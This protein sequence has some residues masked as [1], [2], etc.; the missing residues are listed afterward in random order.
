MRTSGAGIVSVI[1]MVVLAA[2]SAA[3]DTRPSISYGGTRQSKAWI[4]VGKVSHA[5]DEGVAWKGVKVYLS[6]TW[7]LIGVDEATGKALWEQS[8]GAFW[9]EIGFAEVE[10]APG[11]K[12]WAVELRPGR[13]G[14]DG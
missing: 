7:N 4:E 6:L 10:T 1:V 9:N 14:E 3:Q 8:V 5:V 12:T 13:A 2:A 11:V